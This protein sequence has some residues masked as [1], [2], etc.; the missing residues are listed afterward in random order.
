MNILYKSSQTEN[1]ETVT[2]ILALKASRSSN[3]KRKPSRSLSTNS[4]AAPP[5]GY[6]AEQQAAGGEQGKECGPVFQPLIIKQNVLEAAGHQMRRKTGQIK[7]SLCN[8]ASQALG[9]A[10]KISHF[11]EWAPA[12]GRKSFSSWSQLIASL[13]PNK[14]YGGVF[15][16]PETNTSDTCPARNQQAGDIKTSHATNKNIIDSC[17]LSASIF[18]LGNMRLENL[19]GRQMCQNLKEPL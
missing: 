7:L 6:Q 8:Y 1:K 11:S 10:R 5:P 18:T 4:R 3:K 2:F 13:F 17:T 9:T 14:S 15:F 16:F 12:S 19:R